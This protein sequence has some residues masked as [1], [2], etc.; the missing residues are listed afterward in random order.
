MERV[1]KYSWDNANKRANVRDIKEILNLVQWFKWDLGTVIFEGKE[2]RVWVILE[3]RVKN[4]CSMLI[5][6]KNVSVYLNYASGPL[7]WQ[8]L[9]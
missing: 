7:F 4:D 8:K 2:I 6:P 3:A 9:Y 5:P 1:L